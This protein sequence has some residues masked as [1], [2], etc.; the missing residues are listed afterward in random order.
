MKLPILE[1]EGKKPRIHPT[2]YVASNAM[3]IGDVTL[4]EESSVWP[5]AV[6]R[7]DLNKITVGARTNIQEN[8][9]LHV[10]TENPAIVG[11][12]VTIGHGA[13][14]HACTVGNNVLIGMG[15]II[16]EKAT[17]EDWVIVAAGSVII[18]ENHVPAKTLVGGVPAKVIKNLDVQHLALIKRGFEMYVGLSR[19]YV[20]MEAK[21]EKEDL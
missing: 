12:N 5:G 10:T 8:C 18:E 4:G 9:V 17:I 13:I 11:N 7:G 14:V 2:C 20:E 16:L 21:C 15:S 1:F 6:I 19:K 3:L